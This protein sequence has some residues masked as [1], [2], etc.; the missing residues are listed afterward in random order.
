MY[1]RHRD[2]AEPDAEPG[3]FCKEA[4]SRGAVTC[5][6]FRLR[7]GPHRGDTKTDD[8]MGAVAGEMFAA[9]SPTSGPPRRRGRRDC[10][11]RRMS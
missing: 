10:G 9:V 11:R 7:E 4:R 2:R 5:P 3:G 6:P 8:G 1:D